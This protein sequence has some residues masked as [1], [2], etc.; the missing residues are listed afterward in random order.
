MFEVLCGSYMLRSSE[1]GESNGESLGFESAHA[2]DDAVA[3]DG[4]VYDST[5]SNP[6]HVKPY[7][8]PIVIGMGAAGLSSRELVSTLARHTPHAIGAT[9][10]WSSGMSV[11]KEGGGECIGA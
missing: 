3:F 11:R 4:V 1:Q 8:A 10:A 7:A 5:P 2:L 6:R 9:S